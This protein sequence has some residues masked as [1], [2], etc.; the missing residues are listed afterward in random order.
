M[1]IDL[2]TNSRIG[3]ITALLSSF[4][5]QKDEIGSSHLADLCVNSQLYVHSTNLYSQATT[6]VL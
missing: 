4:S 5:Q 3:M 1:P 6:Y 2:T